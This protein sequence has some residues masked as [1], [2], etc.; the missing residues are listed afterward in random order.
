MPW[1]DVPGDDGFQWSLNVARLICALL[2]LLPVFFLACTAAIIFVRNTPH[3]EPIITAVL[4]A[5][6]A[7]VVPIA[8]YVRENMAQIGIGVHLEGGQPWRKH[9]PVYSTFA[10]ATIASFLIAQAPALCGFIASA[11]TRS[12]IPLAIG[13]A[14]SYVAWAMLWP[15]RILWARWTW[16]AKIGRESEVAGPGDGS[17]SADRGDTAGEASS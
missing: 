12:F 8:P 17:R 13:S 15:R 16:Q 11:L 14:V 2:M 9:L 6:A 4:A 7:L 3:E 10:T 1:H 5:I